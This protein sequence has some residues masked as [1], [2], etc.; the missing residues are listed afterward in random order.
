MLRWFPTFQVCTTC[1]SCSPPDLNF[2]GPYFIFMYIRNSHCLRVTA[3]LQLHTLLLL[4]KNICITKI[5]IC[6]RILYHCM[7]QNM[8]KIE[9][10]L[11]VVAWSDTSSNCRFCHP[12]SNMLSVETRFCFWLFWAVYF[13][14]NTEVIG[15]LFCRTLC[16]DRG[17]LGCNIF[18]MSVHQKYL[19][20]FGLL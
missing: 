6:C 13:A 8:N 16:Y 18:T 17:R 14:S 11:S 10:V 2:L 9:I 5:D 12:R 20:Y 1:F 19:W 4:L 3:H 7:L 15:T